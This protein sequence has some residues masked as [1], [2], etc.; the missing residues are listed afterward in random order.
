M[1]CSFFAGRYVDAPRTEALTR[2][3]ESGHSIKLVAKENTAVGAMATEFVIDKQN[4]GFLLADERG[5]ITMYAYDPQ[6]VESRGGLN[7][8]A[9][10]D[11]H[12]GA[13]VSTMLRLPM[14]LQ[15][16]DLVRHAVWF[17]KFLLL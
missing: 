13:K 16:S 1:Q 9:R 15:S 2:L 10:G 3:Q 4:L 11:F 6:A 8:L 7:L 5:N 17:G 14:P 12:V